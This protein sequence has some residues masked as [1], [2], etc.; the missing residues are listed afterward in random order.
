MRVCERHIQL[1]L[2][3]MSACLAKEG[4]R[5]HDAQTVANGRGRFTG[6]VV[7]EFV[8][9]KAAQ[10]KF[11]TDPCDVKAKTMV[12]ELRQTRTDGRSVPRGSTCLVIYFVDAA[13]RAVETTACPSP[14]RAR[15]CD[16]LWVAGCVPLRPGYKR[17]ADHACGRLRRMRCHSPALG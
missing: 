16:A 15:S 11:L 6:C 5:P 12:T 1:G 4:W 7:E 13:G 10:Q 17:E 9:F 8:S 14:T 3:L 2:A